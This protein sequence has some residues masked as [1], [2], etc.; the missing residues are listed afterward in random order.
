VARRSLQV[1]LIAVLAVLISTPAVLARGAGRDCTRCPSRAAAQ[2]A[3]GDP[4]DPFGRDGTDD[5][6]TGADSGTS[7]DGGTGDSAT[8][9]GSGV[10]SAGTLPPHRLHH[11]AARGRG[12]PA[13]ACGRFRAVDDEVPATAR[14]LPAETRALIQIATLPRSRPAC[15]A[16][17]RPGRRSSEVEQAAHNR[18][19]GGSSPPA[20]TRLPVEYRGARRCRKDKETRTNH[21]E[22]EV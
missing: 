6:G 7:A 21:G 12:R 10:T 2:L 22:E 3:Q 20:A 18:C 1:T 17:R 16:G 8:T 4:R 14:G 11:H 9:S 13:P 5:S 19:V 15:A